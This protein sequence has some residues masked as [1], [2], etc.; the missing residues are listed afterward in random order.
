MHYK[1]GSNTWDHCQHHVSL[2]HPSSYLPL[3]LLSCLRLSLVL[4]ISSLF[5]FCLLCPFFFFNTRATGMSKYLMALSQICCMSGSKEPDLFRN[6]SWYETV[7]KTQKEIHILA[8][9][10]AN[11]RMVVQESTVNVK[12]Y[13]EAKSWYDKTAKE[14]WDEREKKMTW[15]EEDQKPTG[16]VKEMTT[17]TRK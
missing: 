4:I 1:S 14:E 5:W 7:T 10:K 16:E 2:P 15:N 8:K 6:T 3:S 17:K 11:K 12:I 13:C 9:R